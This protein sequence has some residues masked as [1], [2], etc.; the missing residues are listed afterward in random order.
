MLLDNSRNCLKFSLENL[1]FTIC[2]NLLTISKLKLFLQN[3]LSL[4]KLGII[5]QESNLL[6]SVISFLN[7][8]KYKFWFIFIL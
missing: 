1:L 3:D 4:F 2:K 5:I 6:L 8:Q 7:I